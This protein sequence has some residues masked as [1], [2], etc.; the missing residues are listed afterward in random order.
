MTIWFVIFVI[1]SKLL[2][3]ECLLCYSCDS[4]TSSECSDPFGMQNTDLVDII[5]CSHE[6]VCYKIKSSSFRFVRGCVISYEFNSLYQMIVD[7]IYYHTCSTNL[8]N[9]CNSNK[10][11]WF[12][13]FQIIV[14]YLF[15]LILKNLY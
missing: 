7:P 9:S 2:L 3:A 8:C 12:F 1:I 6:T 5:T 14:F 11:F 15:S 13:Y 10:Y 4:K